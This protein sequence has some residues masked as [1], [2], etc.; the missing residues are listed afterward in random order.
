MVGMIGLDVIIS[1]ESCLLTKVLVLKLRLPWS[2]L[3]TLLNN[4][5]FV[6]HDFMTNGQLVNSVSSS[7]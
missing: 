6:P 7:S 4:R 5:L 1:L 2:K 3:F